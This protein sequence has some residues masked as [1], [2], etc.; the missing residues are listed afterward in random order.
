MPTKYMFLVGVPLL[1]LLQ[2]DW[3]S[4]R[5]ETNTRIPT[6]TCKHG[7]PR[8]KNNHWIPKR[9]QRRR[10]STTSRGTLFSF[11]RPTIDLASQWFATDNDNDDI[12][13]HSSSSDESIQELFNHD[14]VGM[15]N[16]CLH[17]DLTSPNKDNNDDD[18][19]K[20]VTC[21]TTTTT[22]ASPTMDNNN[23]SDN[24]I[25]EDLDKLWWPFTSM[26]EKMTIP[27]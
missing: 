22:K 21:S 17:I 23:N 24:N 2:L 4:V 26:N 9:Q 16:P 15:T 3:I 20:V 5:A 7:L 10:H 1:L 27:Y 12:M 13:F 8:T 11:R 14:S 6:S 18:I 19:H 25:R